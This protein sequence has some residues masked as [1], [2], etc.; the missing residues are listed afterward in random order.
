VIVVFGIAALVDGG[1]TG[2][3]LAVWFG[4]RGLEGSAA[5]AGCLGLVALGTAA[6][7]LAKRRLLGRAIRALLGLTAGA[8]GLG[9]LVGAALSYD[10]PAL[11]FPVLAAGLWALSIGV[12]LVR[13]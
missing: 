10:Q 13:A 1:L 6:A 8:A 3:G 5:I 12:R 7:E 9:L 11:A 4:G 2:L